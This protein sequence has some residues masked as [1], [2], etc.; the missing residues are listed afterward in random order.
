VHGLWRGSSRVGVGADSMCGNYRRPSGALL[1]KERRMPK[2]KPNPQDLLDLL[3]R[4]ECLKAE[5]ELL[6]VRSEKLRKQMDK[7]AEE[8]VRTIAPKEK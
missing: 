3:Q 4:S 5:A 2:K 1:S 6:R 7:T 8:L